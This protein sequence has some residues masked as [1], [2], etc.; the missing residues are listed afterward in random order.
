MDYNPINY[1]YITYNVR[2]PA[3]ISKLVNITPMSRTGLWYA[4]NEL[5]FLW[6]MV[7]ITYMDPMGNM[8]INEHPQKIPTTHFTPLLMVNYH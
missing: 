7:L 4:N 8:N 6:F 2:P 5:V 3:T 1:R